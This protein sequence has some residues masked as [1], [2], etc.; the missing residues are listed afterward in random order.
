M[1]KAEGDPRRRFVGVLLGVIVI[2]GSVGLIGAGVFAVT[3]R[4]GGTYVDL[5]A[6]GSYG[7]NRYALATDA[8]WRKELFGWAGSVRLKVASG[9]HTPIFVGVAGA[10]AVSR[11]LSGTGYTTIGQHAGRGIVRTD[12]GG[13]APAIPPARAVNW[14]TYAEGVGTQTLDWDAT[15]RPQIVLAMNADGTRPVRVQVVSSAVT[16]S[17]MPW[18][19]SAGALSLGLILLPIG[20]MT[21]R[22]TIRARRAVL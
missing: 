14:T 8:N 20:V 3:T 18:W 7:T 10:D 4:F 22:R 16:L 2:V 15:E 6:H 5:G 13:A 17:R 21:V 9:S 12:H 1:R 19:V 11:Y